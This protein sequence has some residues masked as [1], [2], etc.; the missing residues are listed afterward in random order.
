MVLGQRAKAARESPPPAVT[1]TDSDGTET[2]TQS[3]SSPSMGPIG[4][5]IGFC[6]L[7]AGVVVYLC[8]KDYLEKKEEKA[9]AAAEAKALEEQ[10]PVRR[11]KEDVL[12]NGEFDTHFNGV[13][14]AS[15]TSMETASTKG[16]PAEGEP[17]PE[18]VA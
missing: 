11:S 14:L 13:E 9:K 7:F 4:A 12:I 3:N 17:L 5:G 6:V 18:D 2:Q 10:K 16:E 8:R 1:T 15:L